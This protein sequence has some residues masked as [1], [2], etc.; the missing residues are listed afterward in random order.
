V[1]ESKR[2]LPVRILRWVLTEIRI[3]V[4]RALLAILALILILVVLWVVQSLWG[5]AAAEVADARAL[6]RWEALGRPID[7]RFL[8]EF[9]PRETNEDALVLARLVASVGIEM[10][11]SGIPVTQEARRARPHNEIGRYAWAVAQSVE[12]APEK[13]PEVVRGFCDAQRG[14][15]EAVA[16]FLQ[17]ADPRWT[18]KHDRGLAGRTPD[19]SGHV[20]LQQLLLACAV[21]W[22]RDGVAQ[23]PGRMM[24]ASWRLN[25]PLGERPELISS[26]VHIYILRL[27]AGAL[28]HVRSLDPAWLER[29]EGADPPEAVARGM[30]GEAYAVRRDAM[31]PVPFP[32]GS[33]GIRAD[34]LEKV[35]MRVPGLRGWFRWALLRRVS[36]LAGYQEAVGE[37]GACDFDFGPVNERLEAEIRSWN[38]A[39]RITRPSLSDHD[40]NWTRA[41]RAAIELEAAERVIVFK[42]ALASADRLPRT[43]EALGALARRHGLE[44]GS[45]CEGGRWVHELEEG[46]WVL[47]FEGPEIPAVGARLAAPLEQRIPWPPHAR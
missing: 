44:T 13:A 18:L 26:V 39:S 42:A 45:L 47:R 29:L 15:L 40:Q 38:P 30:R 21:A 33:L 2:S 46:A 4:R 7:D 23:V 9:P 32:W 24:E 27:Q 43:A 36:A 10:A 16:V 3:V 17:G 8:E 22:D 14:N 25:V 35:L 31:D 1:A 11:S 5:W 6:A 37:M 19:L 28:R 34:P 41:R 12:D 20:N